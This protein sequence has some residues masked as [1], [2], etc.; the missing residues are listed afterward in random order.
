MASVTFRC[1]CPALFHLISQT[2]ILWPGLHQRTGWKINVYLKVYIFTLYLFKSMI[3]S[4]STFYILLLAKRV[5][6]FT[7]CNLYYENK[8]IK[9][10]FQLPSA[11]L[12]NPTSPIFSWSQRTKAC[13]PPPPHRN[14]SRGSVQKRHQARCWWLNATSLE[15]SCH[16]S[17]KPEMR[18]VR[19][20]GGEALM[21]GSSFTGQVFVILPQCRCEL[22]KGLRY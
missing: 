2:E 22:A 9:C 20:S 3:P 10:L 18:I 6:S 12:S 14:S 16:M 11:P 5:L 4:D 13:P 19:P 7:F 17:E 1:H 21:Q 15:L 8:S